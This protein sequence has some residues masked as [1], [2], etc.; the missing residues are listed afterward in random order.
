MPAAETVGKLNT[1]SIRGW[2]NN[3][4]GW[5][6]RSNTLT[7]DF[8]FNHFRDSIVFVNRVATLADSFNHRPEIEVRNATVKLTLS[9]QAV[10]GITEKDLDLAEQIDF[11]TSAS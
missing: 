8:S 10:G 2:L 7:K 4:R 1:E 5:K 3:R 9:T 6:R 11:A